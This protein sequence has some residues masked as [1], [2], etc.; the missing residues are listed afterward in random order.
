MWVSGSG[1]P[2]ESIESKFKTIY[3]VSQFFYQVPENISEMV[4]EY[5]FCIF[6]DMASELKNN[7][8]FTNF[9]PKLPT[10]KIVSWPTSPKMHM[11]QEWIV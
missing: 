6:N 8:G 3:C 4:Q 1:A 7:T 5:D 9:L 10:T 11:N 2:N